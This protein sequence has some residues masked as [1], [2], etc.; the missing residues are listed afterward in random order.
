MSLAHE[1]IEEQIESRR[2]YVRTGG[3]ERSGMDVQN[4]CE[5]RFTTFGGSEW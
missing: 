5:D 1:R 2:R 3:R 4:E